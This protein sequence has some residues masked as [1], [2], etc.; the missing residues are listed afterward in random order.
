[1]H[2]ICVHDYCV[3]AYVYILFPGM[4]AIQEQGGWVLLPGMGA[5]Q[6]QGGRVSTRYSNHHIKS[7]LLFL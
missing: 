7:L 6:E 1:M 2:F 4:G 5:T 3:Y